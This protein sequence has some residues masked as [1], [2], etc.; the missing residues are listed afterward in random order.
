MM[1][2]RDRSI[3]HTTDTEKTREI[4]ENF[5]LPKPEKLDII[6]YIFLLRSSPSSSSNST[7][8]LGEEG[9]MVG[10]TQTNRWGE[11]GLEMGYFMLEKFTGKGYVTEGVRGFLELFWSLPGMFVFP[12]YPIKPCFIAKVGVLF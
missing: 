11:R 2:R 3:S 5:L 12:R 9:E 6:K 10:W 7:G 1:L 4:V 8:I